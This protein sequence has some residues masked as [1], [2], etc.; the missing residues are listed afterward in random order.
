MNGSHLAQLTVALAATIHRWHRKQT[1]STAALRLLL[2]AMLTM[3]DLATRRI[4]NGTEQLEL[5]V[6]CLELVIC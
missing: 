3:V 5:D 6:D 2:P 4:I 1:D